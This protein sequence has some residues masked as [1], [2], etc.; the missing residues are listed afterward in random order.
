LC[1]AAYGL[2]LG[3]GDL[4]KMRIFAFALLYR[5]KFMLKSMTGFGSATYETETLSIAVEVRSVNSK[6]LDISYRSIGGFLDKELEVKNLIGKILERGK[7][8]LSIKFADK[9]SVQL[10]IRP[11]VNLIKAYYRELEGLAT[12]VGADK[13]DLFRLVLGL[14][15]AYISTSQVES[16]RE[17]H[18]S[19]I[20]ELIEKA[21]HLCDQF[22]L[23]EGK[24]L[25]K[26]F[27]TCLE[28]IA[29]R[30]QWI[31][32]KD[33][34][35]QQNLRERLERQLGELTKSEHFDRNRFEQELI[36]YIEKLDISEEKVRLQSHLDYFSQELQAPQASGKKL[37]FI[38]QEMGREIN[39]IGAKANHALIQRW[40]VE[41]KEELEKIKEQSLN[42][43]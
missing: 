24:N 36:Y 13:S 4:K 2:N 25:E 11:N 17:K 26:Q 14:P 39:T 34:E 6:F 31:S 23:E 5:V 28:T 18:W 22:R 10:P 37:H 19:L 40:V 27:Q 42:V 8:H 38:S 3:K 33:P 16:E 12:E 32:E 43:L 15:E 1:L 9:T 30:L 41:M 7:I 35:R 29:E 21:L 20:L